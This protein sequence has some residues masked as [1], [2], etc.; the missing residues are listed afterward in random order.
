MKVCFLAFS[1]EICRAWSWECHAVC[2]LMHLGGKVTTFSLT[3]LHASPL[4]ASPSILAIFPVAV[5]KNTPTKRRLGRRGRKGL[6]CYRSRENTV[7]KDRDDTE[8]GTLQRW[9][10]RE[11]DWGCETSKPIPVMNDLLLPERLYSP[12]T[13]L[14]CATRCSNT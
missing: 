2:V 10:K 1:M 3:S 11:W 9:K 14:T 4:Q 7:C 12:T 8:V 5:V 13:F 6:L